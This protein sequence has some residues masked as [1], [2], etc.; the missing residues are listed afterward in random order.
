MEWVCIAVGHRWAATSATSAQFP[1]PVLVGQA[2]QVVASIAHQT[3]SE[4][5][6]TAMITN[7]EGKPCTEAAATFL[8]LGEAQSLRFAEAAGADEGAIESSD[9]RGDINDGAA[10][11]APG[12]R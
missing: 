8:I 12:G 2:F 5:E 11:N 7:A 9:T 6:T 4:I 3:D 1:R 10:S